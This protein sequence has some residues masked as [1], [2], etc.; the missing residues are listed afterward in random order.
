MSWMTADEG[1]TK[2]IG[3]DE[4][5]LPILQ[6]AVDR[7][8]VVWGKV[9][10]FMNVCLAQFTWAGCLWEMTERQECVISVKLIR[11]QPNDED[12]TAAMLIGKIE[13]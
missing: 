1:K 5:L 3:F 12:L 2:C 4:R 11:G 6:K 10:V 9:S 8:F 7:K 13:T